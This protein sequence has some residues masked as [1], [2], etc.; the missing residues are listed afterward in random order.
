VNPPE[1]SDIEG[2]DDLAGA[3]TATEGQLEAMTRI[4]ELDDELD[5][6]SG[7]FV[8]V[9]RWGS[10]IEGDL[11]AARSQV[12]RGDSDAALETLASA[13]VRIDDLAA[14]GRVRVLLA[15]ALLI[16]AIGV[17]VVIAVV[18]RSRRADRRHDPG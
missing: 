6:A 15:G 14:A 13:E 7:I 2:V 4:V 8:T 10:D 17:I 9:G 11:D 12:E 3:I 1:L 16:V 18:A 5:A